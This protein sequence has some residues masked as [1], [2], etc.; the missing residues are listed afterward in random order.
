MSDRPTR[1]LSGLATIPE[2][3]PAPPP[4]TVAEAPTIARGPPP[5]SPLPGGPTAARHDEDTRLGSG[6]RRH[7]ADAVN[8]RSSAQRPIRIG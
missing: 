6:E 3:L 4:S 1:K 2:P 8:A 5:S 7:F